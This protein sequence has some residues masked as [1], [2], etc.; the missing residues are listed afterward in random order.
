M[1]RV[2]HKFYN[3]QLSSKGGVKRGSNV[4]QSEHDEK[5]GHDDFG[6]YGRRRQDRNWRGCGTATERETEG[7][8]FSKVSNGIL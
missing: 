6:A 8:T 2:Q 3:E 7:K 5:S 1:R 4:S